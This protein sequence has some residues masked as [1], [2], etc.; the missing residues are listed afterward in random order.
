M[1]RETTLGIAALRNP[2]NEIKREPVAAMT[3]H[4]ALNRKF[5]ERENSMSDSFIHENDPG[6]EEF[7][8][9]TLKDLGERAQKKDICVECLSD[10]L[11]IELV[12][13]I[14][15]SGVPVSAI[16]AM[17]GEGMDAAEADFSSEQQ[18]RARRMH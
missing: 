8:E 18:K 7:I 6:F 17:V 9:D 12:S 11:I 16:L 10:R 5:G 4:L 15:R 2:I 1:R 3:A 14:A 13:G